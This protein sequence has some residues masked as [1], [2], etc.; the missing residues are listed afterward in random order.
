[1][2]WMALTIA[3]AVGLGA[4][5]VP[6]WQTKAGGKMAFEGASVKLHKG[7]FPLDNGDACA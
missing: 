7:P 5:D 3:P 4:Q 6:D 2:A 1:M